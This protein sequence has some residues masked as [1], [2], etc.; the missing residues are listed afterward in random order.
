MPM[1][2]RIVRM[3]VI[4]R[5]VVIVIMRMVVI[6]RM[7]VIMWMVVIVIV[8]M[9]MVMRMVM[10]VGTVIVRMVVND[11]RTTVSFPVSRLRTVAS[12]SPHPQCPHI[13][14]PPSIPST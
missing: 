6:T 4:V 9:V 8:R 12:A 5:T 3:V 14:Q 7:V 10:I 13:T 2:R 1:I 11:R